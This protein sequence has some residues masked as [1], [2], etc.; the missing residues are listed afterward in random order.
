MVMLADA[1]VPCAERLPEPA[2]LR[3]QL[4]ALALE[5]PGA[6]GEIAE[7]LGSALADA[8]RDHLACAGVPPEA[9]LAAAQGSPRE[10]RLWV[11]GERRWRPTA[12]SLFGRAVR[13]SAAA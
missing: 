11:V 13:R 3:E 8:W 6:A 9:L 10:L 5:C 2:G 7:R 4:L 1:T 12:E